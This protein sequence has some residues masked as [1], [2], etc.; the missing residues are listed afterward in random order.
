VQSDDALVSLMRAI[1][2][3][4]HTTSSTLL[5]KQPTLVSAQL[6]PTEWFFEE[7]HHQIYC[8]DTALHIAAA[9]F[10]PMI[11]GD[12]VRRG[13]DVGI[14]NRRGARPLHYAMD[15]V[16]GGARWNPA[17][18]RETVERLLELGADPDAPDKNGTPP[19][20][21]AVRN[22][23]ASAVDALLV[24]GA[25]PHAMNKKGSTA[26][27]LAQVTSG[28]GGSGSPEALAQ[29]EAI[30]RLLRSAGSQ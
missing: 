18:Q 16:P 23:C 5:D 19:L 14:E 26:M 21:R 10:E 30:I 8:G 4:D 1:A 22:R 29:Q 2:S 11:V 12:L 15:G 6:G 24:A 27:Q 3:G 28:R 7:L 25:D 17:T 13:S 9:A 20:L